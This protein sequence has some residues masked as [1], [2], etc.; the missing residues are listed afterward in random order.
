[1]LTKN[2]WIQ[3]VNEKAKAGSPFFLF[4]DFEMQAP[5][6]FRPEQLAPADIWVQFPH[7]Q[8]VHPIHPSRAV[9]IQCAH[10]PNMEAYRTSF[11]RVMAGLLYGNSYLCNLTVATPVHVRGSLSD[12]FHSATAKYKI[13]FQDEWVCFSPE[14]FIR[15]QGNTISTYPMKG[16]L[17]ADLPGAEAQ[18]LNDAKERAEHFTIVDLLRNDLSRIAHNVQVKR[19]RYLE[20]LNTS[21]KN[22][23]QC[24]SEITGELE[25]DWR[26][27]LGD[28][29]VELLPAG[30]IS[31]APKKSTCALIRDAEQK[32]RGYYTGVAF[33]FDGEN[34]DSTVMIRFLE[35]TEQGFSYRSGGGITVNSDCELEFQECLDKIYVPRI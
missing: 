10:E 12:V 26:N 32:T 2:N 21:S 28:I 19:F 16:T 15:I 14:M 11:N 25:S 23:L 6:L 29:L 24:S 1:M 34:L 30:S 13:R 22:L 33:Y 27:R 20:T 7:L 5:L 18:L 4:T 9:S 3:A 17:D 8:N 35:K 31:G